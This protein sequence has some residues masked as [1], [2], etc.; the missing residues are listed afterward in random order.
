MLRFS[1]GNFVQSAADILTLIEGRQLVVSN[2]SVILESL[3]LTGTTNRLQLLVADCDSTLVLVITA[4]GLQRR[5]KIQFES[6]LEL[7]RAVDTLRAIIAV[8]QVSTKSENSPTSQVPAHVVAASENLSLPSH[9]STQ[10][11]YHSQD[12]MH[13]QTIPQNKYG[14]SHLSHRT[15]S[16]SSSQVECCNTACVPIGAW[17]DKMVQAIL[18]ALR[19]CIFSLGFTDNAI[20]FFYLSQVGSITQRAHVPSTYGSSGP[21]ALAAAMGLQGLCASDVLG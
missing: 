8:T 3:D 7:T 6:Q 19:P 10:N 16:I 11:L 13:A 15:D 1:D 14:Q 18:P 17:A 9:A 21:S 20:F 5:F 12:D 4:R 2:G